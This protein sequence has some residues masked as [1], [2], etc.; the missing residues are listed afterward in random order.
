[1]S[2][3]DHLFESNRKWAAAMEEQ[4]P[5]FF[6]QLAEQQAPKYMWIGCSD[7]RVPANEVVGLHP[8]ELF[9]HR[10]VANLVVHTDFNCLSALQFAVDTLNVEHII[11]CGHYGCGGIH[12]ALDPNPHGLVDNWLRHI[13]D[14]FRRK[15]MEI[16]RIEDPDAQVDRLC[17]L[18]VESQ[19][20][21]V[22]RN[23]VVR[24][25][26]RQ[27]RELAVHG[28]IYEMHSGLL[29]DLDVSISSLEDLHDR[30]HGL[31]DEK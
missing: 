31:I 25:A 22:A 21:N 4:R 11:V 2:D 27:N 15:R 6:E 23:T 20:L 3:T 26:W 29:K 14:L 19:V 5:G 10:N 13:A 30:E 17:E 1:M 12:A 7:S 24:E 9:V 28:W 8:G 18:N 16:L